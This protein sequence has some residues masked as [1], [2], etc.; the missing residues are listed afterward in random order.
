M[1]PEHTLSPLRRLNT[2]LLLSALL[3][4]A[5]TV[6][7]DEPAAG[8]E[9]AG[10]IFK[11][12]EAQIVPAFKDSKKW[13]RQNLWVETEFDSDGDGRKDRMH[14]D[15]TRPEQTDTEN[16]KVPVI[17]ETSPYYAGTGSNSPEV[18]WNPRHELNVAPAR[19]QAPKPIPHQEGMQQISDT[20]VNDWVPRGFAVVHSCSPGTGRSQGCPTVGGPNESLAPKAVIDWLDRKSVV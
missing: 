18:F 8:T 16:L 15:V 1:Q 14:V 12:G 3:A 11:D 2:C 17:Y 20:H 10:P 4:S 9:K 13:I 6:V 19:H 5:G 7:A